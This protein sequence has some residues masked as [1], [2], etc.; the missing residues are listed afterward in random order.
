MAAARAARALATAASIVVCCS[1]IAPRVVA[2]QQRVAAHSD[3]VTA[4]RGGLTSP[5]LARPISISLTDV[6][7]EA[8]LRE[9]ALR[10][11]LRLSYSSD[12]I[13]ADRRVT[14]VREQAAVGDVIH[15]VLRDTDLDI[16]VSPS[17]YVILV[18]L[19]GRVMPSV[20]A[21]FADSAELAPTPLQV[22]AAFR[23]QVMDRMLIMGASATGA[24]ERSLTSAV[25]VLTAS[26]IAQ[27]GATS[28]EQLF[29]NAIPGVV[30]WDLGISGPFAQIGS[31]RGS[32]SFNNNYLKTY[33]DG[34]E[35]ASPYL[36]FAID[37]YSVERI[38]VIRGPQGS[39]LYGSDA[40]SGVVQIITRKG[41]PALKW[42]PQVDAAL[43][44]GMMESSFTERS[45]GTQ[46]HSAM[47]S[48]GGGQSSLG[49]G[50]TF[51]N[52]GAIA[53][54]GSS[55]YRG[56]FG[57]GRTVL[58]PLRLDGTFRYA[59]VRFVAPSNPLLGNNPVPSTIR[60]LLEAQRIENETY[61]V[62]ADFQ[63]RGWWRQTLVLGIDRHSGAI[64]PQREPATVAD[65]LL[66]ATKENVS[67]SSLRY[68][69]AVRLVDRG[70]LSLS[71]TLG[72]ERSA[73]LRER[74]GFRS[75]LAGTGTGLA[76]LYNDKVDNSGVF[77]Q[78]KLELNN[79]VFFTAGLRGE[80]NSSFGENYG[81][82]YAPMLGAAVTRDL[83]AATVKFRAAYGK[84]IRP[85]PP[86]ARRDIQTIG[87][88]QMANP[89]LQPEV[90][91]GTEAGIELYVGD[92]ANLSLT[93]YSQTADGLV[94]QV[95]ANRRTSARTV[96][97]QN[98]GRIHNRGVE[99]EG[100]A[101]S[102]PF[103]GDLTF[104]LTDSRVEALS[105]LY[106][107][108]LAIGDR[109]PEVPSSAGMASLSWDAWRIRSMVGANYTGSWL[110]YDWLGFYGSEMSPGPMGIGGGEPSHYE[111]RNFWVNY[112]SLVKPFVGLTYVLGRG[113]EWYLRVDN[114]TNV[115]RNE[116]DNLQI[117]QGRTTTF[118]LRLSR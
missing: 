54:G 63:P 28:M 96:Q 35:L 65:A 8:A 81:T 43:T 78:V 24:P 62:T 95:V 90:Q 27:S 59:D 66:G 89:E 37:P 86:N 14:V 22:R 42:K 103:R 100:S 39:A 18:K 115:Q 97:F 91:S 70:D 33:V 34:I 4:A 105:H 104:A 52:A 25:S 40:I 16:V 2:G 98:V 21:L 7:I 111:S 20:A 94:Q 74:L 87:F 112:P 68:A 11:L 82:A 48:A 99:L 71:A 58:G 83:G 55:G 30:A 56:T 38:E 106:T 1:A 53:P 23:P 110:G 72:A 31:V 32:S 51:E 64:A 88:R 36:L 108:D 15:D 57:G 6:S 93:T 19:P 67:K 12:I 116:R 60:P 101:R 10:A 29:R 26:Q 44:G 9:I 107:G 102:G 69:M 85:P 50:G 47:V 84:G 76:S 92:R 118:G 5:L 109:V 114:L 46:H 75:E 45:S 13:P 80:R 3:S 113:A 17:G 79:S 49:F 73:L 117:T 41:T 61:G 77:G